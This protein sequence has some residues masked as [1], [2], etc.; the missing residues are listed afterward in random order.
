MREHKRK[1]MYADTKM[2]EECC[3]GK[4][5]DRKNVL[6]RLLGSGI[7]SGGGG[8]TVADGDMKEKKGKEHVIKVIHK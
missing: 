7:G 6:G 3:I 2:E 5:L 8:R 1:R 4:G